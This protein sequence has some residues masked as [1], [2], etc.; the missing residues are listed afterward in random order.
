ME[1]EAFTWHQWEDTRRPF[2]SWEDFK[3]LL[4]ERFGQETKRRCPR[5]F[6]LSG[7]RV[8]FVSIAGTSNGLLP[9]WMTFQNVS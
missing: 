3:G 1:G 4:L 7:K 9:P 6:F 5:G 8:L 2:R